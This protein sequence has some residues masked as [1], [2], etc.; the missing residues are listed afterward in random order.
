M[1]AGRDKGPPKEPFI[2]ELLMLIFSDIRREGA[3]GRDKISE[4]V[5]ASRYLPPPCLMVGGIH[6]LRHLIHHAVILR[7]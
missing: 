3:F 2:V 1:R 4:G 7:K 6:C 5:A